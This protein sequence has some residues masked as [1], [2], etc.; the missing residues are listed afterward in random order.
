MG[1]MIPPTR[2][3]LFNFPVLGF[4]S[5]QNQVEPLFSRKARENSS[6]PDSIDVH[7]SKQDSAS[8]STEALKFAGTLS[9]KMEEKPIYSMTSRPSIS[10]GMQP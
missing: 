10:D 7:S 1:P 6:F 9:R 2:I 5:Y 4:S 3:Y 8:S